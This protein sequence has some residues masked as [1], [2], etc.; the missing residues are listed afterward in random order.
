MAMD[1]VSEKQNLRASQDEVVRVTGELRDSNI[2]LTRAK[3]QHAMA[4][5]GMAPQGGTPSVDEHLCGKETCIECQRKAQEI[6][7]Q[8]NARNQQHIAA[9]IARV[10]SPLNARI[11]SLEAQLQAARETIALQL[12]GNLGAGPLNGNAEIKI[13]TRPSG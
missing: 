12:G 10:S 3:H 2:E 11:A 6:Q 9:I 5:G 13:I 1:L 4:L 8:V 7:A